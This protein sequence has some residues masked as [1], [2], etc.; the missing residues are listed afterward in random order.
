MLHDFG[1]TEELTYDSAFEYSDKG[2]LIGHIVICASMIEEEVKKLSGFPDQLKNMLIHLVLS[3]Q[4][5]LEY[6]SPDVPKTVEAIALDQADELSAK[7]NAYSGTLKSE[8]LSDGKW[9]K[10]IHLA[11]TDLYKHTISNEIDIEKNKS[12]FD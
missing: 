3:H 10:F 12:L 6:A 1:K 5:K 11:Q 8:I 7:V 4:G 2:K 9:T